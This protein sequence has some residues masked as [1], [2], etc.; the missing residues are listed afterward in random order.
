MTSNL[1]GAGGRGTEATILLESFM[2][3]VCSFVFLKN[4]NGAKIDKCIFM[5]K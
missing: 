2:E 5:Q 1:I 4:V 3:N